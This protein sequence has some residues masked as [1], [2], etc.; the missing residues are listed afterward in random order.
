MPPLAYTS[1]SRLTIGVLLAPPPVQLLDLAPVDVF[2]MISKAYLQPLDLLPQ[3]LKDLAVREVKIYYI[4]AEQ[5]SSAK[6]TSAT[7]AGNTAQLAPLTADL[8]VQI[9]STC[10]SLEV[11][12]GSL[13]LLFIPGPDPSVSTPEV[14]RTFIQAHARCG[15]TDIITV[16][17]GIFP[18]CYSGICDGQI[19]TGP[20]GLLS[21][22]RK[23]FKDVKEFEDKRW[24]STALVSEKK[25]G[26]A[27]RP[28]ELWTAAGITN[29]HDCVAAYIKAHFNSELADVVCRMCDIG[30][31]SRDYDT[32]Q[33]SE[34]A[35]WMSRILTAAVKGLF[36]RG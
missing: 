17:T 18:A 15:S 10:T 21:D 25:T 26:H 34:T 31:R 4:A 30:D 2:H 1:S 20:R 8:N 22:L 33:A 7:S 23:K 19:V 11:Q 29:G 24:S 32:G 35:W 36:R 6:T 13:N 3:P 14:Y 5:S 28:A 9:T 16:C 12:P 27:E